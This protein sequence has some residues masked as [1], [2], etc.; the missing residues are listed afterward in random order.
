MDDLADVNVVDEDELSRAFLQ[1]CW[2]GGQ[3]DGGSLLQ[4]HFG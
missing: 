2:I 1:E 4:F 3:L